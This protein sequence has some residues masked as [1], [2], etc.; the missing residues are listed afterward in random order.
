MSYLLLKK[1]VMRNLIFLFSFFL[2][3]NTQVKSQIEKYE[4]EEFNFVFTDFED[5]K[6]NRFRYLGKYEGEP[7]VMFIEDASVKKWETTIYKL[8]IEE[9][10]TVLEKVGFANIDLPLN[11]HDKMK[12][13]ISEG[14]LVLFAFDFEVMNMNLIKVSAA[15]YNLKTGELEKKLNVLETNITTIKI[16]NMDISID[17]KRDYISFSFTINR[18]NNTDLWSNH[19]TLP[20]DYE[21]GLYG[22]VLSTKDLSKPLKTFF[23]PLKLKERALL[24]NEFDEIFSHKIL[25]DGEKVKV[26]VVGRNINGISYYKNGET[27]F[28]GFVIEYNDGELKKYNFLPG[29]KMISEYDVFPVKD[30]QL[31]VIGYYQLIDKKPLPNQ[32]GLFVQNI[33]TSDYDSTDFE[34]YP[35]SKNEMKNA[36]EFIYGKN[37]SR[38][39]KRIEKRYNPIGA[40][41]YSNFIPLEKSNIII[42]LEAKKVTTTTTTEHQGGVTTSTI[43]ENYYSSGGY[44]HYFDKEYE[45]TKTEI[46]PVKQQGYKS[47]IGFTKMIK[48]DKVALFYSNHAQN[49]GNERAYSAAAQSFDRTLHF[50]MALIDESGINFFKVSEGQMNFRVDNAFKIDNSL[51]IPG[52]GKKNISSIFRI[53]WK[54]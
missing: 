35:F 47:F 37:D 36:I 22:Q 25:F 6:S 45:P 54:D 39:I 4:G 53:D 46:L 9:D 38:N 29:T 13:L 15:Y 26:Y 33:N 20:D 43:D 31:K 41:I 49:H 7:Y 1:N 51:F 44:I 42:G 50:E 23:I 17:E 16:S 27:Y 19:N 32:D 5:M 3:F 30:G 2:L 11:S 18:Q 8:I 24:Q 10:E 12:F 48:N 21:L 14:H 28:Y 52:Y 34:L 40:L